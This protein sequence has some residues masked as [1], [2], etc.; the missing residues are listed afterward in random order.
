MPSYLRER[1]ISDAEIIDLYGRG[2]DSD[3]IGAR[4]GCSGSTVLKIVRDAGH[5]VR[6][7]GGRP[8]DYQRK[9][10][11]KEIVRRY[12]IGMT[13]RELAE[14]AGCTP[15]AIFAILHRANVSVRPSNRSR[16][17]STAR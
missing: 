13:G 16:N 5:P 8:A 14:A 2:L 11:D 10:S 1:R 9:L 3:S 12:Q 6:G 4:A 7:R 15:T 17:K